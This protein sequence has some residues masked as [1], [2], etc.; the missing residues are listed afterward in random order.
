M[1]KI[2]FGTRERALLL[3]LMSMGG[4]ATNP[5]LRDHVGDVIDGAPRRKLNELR[6]VKSVR[7]GRAYRHELLEEGW[8]WCA[9]ELSQP[10]PARGGAL[11]VRSTYAVFRYFDR[12]FD[13]MGVSLGDIANVIANE[14]VEAEAEADLP[15]LIREAY[16]RVAAKPQ[17]WVL[18]TKMRPLLG[19]VPR[20]AVD[21][22]LRLM[23]LLPD[24][25]LA[26]EADQK[27]LTEE[28]REA[29]VTVGGVQN[30]LLAIEAR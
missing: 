10:A 6:M 15:T 16:W 3:G 25:H 2:M 28:D 18:L 13:L 21:E 7:E 23:Q 9:A 19:H 17:E 14:E 20:T 22:A 24:V 5:G 26:P 27:T 12:Y 8:A 1:D 29:A 30:H 11:T 4:T